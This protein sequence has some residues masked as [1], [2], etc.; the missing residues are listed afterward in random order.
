VVFNKL[1]ILFELLLTTLALQRS[2]NI[3]EIMALEK[4]IIKLKQ[5]ST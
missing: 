5:I 1:E 4:L 2:S 3:N